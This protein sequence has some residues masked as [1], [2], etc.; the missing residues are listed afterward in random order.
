M[1][2]KIHLSLLACCLFL[3]F[4][5]CSPKLKPDAS[6]TTSPKPTKSVVKK[7]VKNVILLIGDG[8]G[9]A[10]VSSQFYYGS[11]TPSFKRFKYIGLHENQPVGAKVTDSAA[12]ATAFS[13]GYKSYNGAI[14]V[15]GD[16]IPRETIAEIAHFKGKKVGLIATSSIT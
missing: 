13:T 6:T 16:T 5:S 8:M 11:K 10:Q 3:I 7:K 4:Q 2:T 14:G 15:D 1:M 12:G 9:L